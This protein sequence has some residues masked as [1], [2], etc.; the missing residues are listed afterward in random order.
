MGSELSVNKKRKVSKKIS[1]KMITQR[2][3]FDDILLEAIDECFACL[4]ESPKNTI[5]FYLERKFGITKE[6][7]PFSLTDF[8]VALEKMFGIGTKYLEVQFMEKLH[9]KIKKLQKENAFETRDPNFTF[10][11]YVNIKRRQFE[12]SSSTNGRIQ[13]L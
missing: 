12:K 5:Y 7:I 1:C 6:E 3:I 10:I 9:T 13:P 4:G 2:K 11:D 8:S